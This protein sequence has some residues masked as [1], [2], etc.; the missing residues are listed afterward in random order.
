MHSCWCANMIF[1][2]DS[3]EED[4]DI[5]LPSS[6]Q[7]Q[8]TEHPPPAQHAGY[9]SAEFL[10]AKQAISRNQHDTNAWAI[11]LDEAEKSGSKNQSLNTLN[12][13]TSQYPRSSAVW[14][15]YIDVLR[16]Y[17]E[18]Q[19]L[20]DAYR[21]CLS[22]CR[23]VDLWIS[24]LDL[25]RSRTVALQTSSSEQYEDKKKSH[26][27]SFEN[28]LENVGASVDAY[29][30]WR[31]YIDFVLE[32]P[33]SNESDSG[34]KITALRELYQRA[35]STP[36][37][38]LDKFWKEY[39]E[40]E[41][42]SGKHLA[43]QLLPEFKRKYQDAKN[44]CRER[45]KLWSPINEVSIPSL[46][47]DMPSTSEKN[48]LQAW[49]HLIQ[50]EL[51]NPHD[52]SE[53][54][55]RAVMDF[56]FDKLLS[57]FFFYPEV[58]IM[59]SKYQSQYYS[60]DDARNI[61]N[62][63]LNHIPNV[64]TLWMA[65]AQFE[66][67]CG[68]YNSALDVLRGCFERNPSSFSFAL[69][70]QYVRR[71]EGKNA[72]RRLFSDTVALREEGILGIESYVAH[73]SMELS[74]NLEPNIALRVLDLAK[75]RHSS[76]FENFRYILVLA[77][78]LVR[79]GDFRQLRWVFDTHVGSVDN[80]FSAT[81]NF[82]VEEE[83]ML[84]KYYLEAEISMGM[85]ETKRLLLV[86]EKIVCIEEQRDFTSKPRFDLFEPIR[87]LC[88]RNMHVNVS[89][90]SA[91]SALERRAKK[92]SAKRVEIAEFAAADNSDCTNKKR[93]REQG[94]Q[95]AELE[96]VPIFLRSLL[97][98]LPAYTGR[99][100]DTKVFID[101][102]KESVLPPRPVTEESVV[103]SDSHFSIGSHTIGQSRKAMTKATDD[104]DD[105]VEENTNCNDIFRQRRRQKLTA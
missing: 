56:T 46:P 11:L 67:E 1:E 42:K 80:G 84:W 9:D 77:K 47:P 24:Y 74:V 87:L 69:L 13:A 33:E 36:M 37:N 48:Q 92:L 31:R 78:V 72:A 38:D 63:G 89:L 95:E 5:E 91:D 28:A 82:D 104:F 29:M 88:E 68:N 61:L 54:S 101:Q 98:G 103:Y 50:V 65:L 49:N 96:G 15:R 66:E 35:V 100:L 19:L 71:K 97:S 57:N 43:E 30:I 3:S 79:L 105:D 41:M 99:P 58:W 14:R 52:L 55:L 45:N 7:H 59:A 94:T 34:R 73:A 27:N 90:P 83:I 62:E 39:E 44:I 17:D 21:K 6:L 53:V 12:E 26:E 93:K 102:L 8:G 85:C 20:E 86:Q 64:P 81:K 18:M 40:W 70:Q 32:W 76:V 23:S 16:R 2:S 25:N 51:K 22:K 4:E 60:K 75:E 10:E